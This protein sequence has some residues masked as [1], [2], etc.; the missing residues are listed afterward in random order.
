[1]K[2]IKCV[3]VGN[4]AV[5]KTCLIITYIEN[6]FPSEYVPT[7][8]TNYSKNVT[9]DGKSIELGLWDT[10]GQIDYDR[11]RPLSYVNPDIFLIC[12][13]LISHS[14]FDSVKNKWIQE[15]RHYCP[16][17]PIILVGLKSELR[18]DK[19][20]IDNLRENNQQPISYPQGEKLAE[21][22]KAIKYMECSALTQEGVKE[23]FEEAIRIVL[24][25]PKLIK[26]KSNKSKCTLL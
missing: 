21:S 2:A 10:A 14:S 11:L 3:V 1:M 15:V 17:A 18:N 5:G 7:V 12:F 25:P 9:I 26:L 13:S 19:A 6:S 23:L 24:N 20:F 4:G 8:F 22:I 16:S